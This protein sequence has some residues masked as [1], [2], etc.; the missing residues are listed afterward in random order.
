MTTLPGVTDPG[1][2]KHVREG[3]PVIDVHGEHVGTVAE[4]QM[5]DPQAVTGQGQQM[6]GEG[7]LLGAVVRGL[8]G[9]S[10]LSTQEQ[11]Q[12]LRVGYVQIDGSGMSGKSYVAADRIRGVADGRVRL[13][14]AA[15]DLQRH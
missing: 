7:G 8:G 10:S 12:L 4:V 3:M 13:A 2:I 6:S 14:A 9:G 11:E 15:A 5:G 1:P